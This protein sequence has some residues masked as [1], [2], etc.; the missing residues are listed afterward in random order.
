MSWW[1]LF[2]LTIRTPRVELRYLDDALMEELVE[3]A[4]AGIVDDS[5]PMPFLTP[6]IREEPPAFQRKSMQWHWKNRAEVSAASWVL[7]FAIVVG[8]EVVGAQDLVSRHF[9]V[10]RQVQTGSWLGRDHQGKGTGKEMRSA[11]LHLAFEGLG[12]QAAHT[13]AFEDNPRS[14]GVTKALGYEPNGWWVHDREGA[15]AR[16]ERYVM[17]R[18]RWLEGRRDDITIEGLTPDVLD[19]LGLGLGQREGGT[20]A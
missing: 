18:D 14:L 8:G 10:A 15:P 6:W 19:L 9:P 7:P 4:A 13:E 2:G 1:P 20:D 5:G 12:A 3:A 17:T 16:E 11:V